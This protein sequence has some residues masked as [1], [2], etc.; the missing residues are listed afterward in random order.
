M[1]Q[2]VDDTTGSELSKE[3]SID[4]DIDAVLTVVM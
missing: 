1:F 2:V 4:Q 3:G